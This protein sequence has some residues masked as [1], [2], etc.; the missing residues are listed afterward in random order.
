MLVRH[1]TTDYIQTVLDSMSIPAPVNSVP[2]NPAP[3]QRVNLNS[4]AAMRELALEMSALADKSHLEPPPQR[5][6][7]ERVNWERQKLDSLPRS[8]CSL[9]YVPDLP[10][11]PFFT[12][13]SN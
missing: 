3:V 1:I 4:R 12:H 11:H 2:V 5:S 7:A 8:T 10:L 6:L 13:S 9:L